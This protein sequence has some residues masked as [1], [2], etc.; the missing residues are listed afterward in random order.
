[1]CTHLGKCKEIKDDSYVLGEFKVI[2]LNYNV[3]KRESEMCTSFN[4]V[5]R[6][7]V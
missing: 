7:I 1:M 6:L 2:F 3:I 5:F 4:K